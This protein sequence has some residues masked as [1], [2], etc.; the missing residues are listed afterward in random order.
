M[1]LKVLV[2]MSVTR[3]SKCKFHTDEGQ[4]DYAG[5]FTFKIVSQDQTKFSYLNDRSLPN[6]SRIW[7]L[8]LSYAL[9]VL[10]VQ[11]AQHLLIQSLYVK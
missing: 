2:E 5:T 7:F 3:Y 1:F 10:N 9:H 8:N 11:K 4:I 6:Q